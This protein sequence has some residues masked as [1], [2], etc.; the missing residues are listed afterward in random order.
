MF[1]IT[2]RFTPMPTMGF[3]QRNAAGLIQQQGIQGPSAAAAPQQQRSLP[4]G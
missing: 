1:G 4:M 3:R 2:L